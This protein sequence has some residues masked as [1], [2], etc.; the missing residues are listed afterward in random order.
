MAIVRKKAQMWSK[1]K[2]ISCY[3][4][5]IDH[6]LKKNT[7]Q[8][9]KSDDTQST[10]WLVSQFISK[11]EIEYDYDRMCKWYFESIWKWNEFPGNV[12]KMT[13]FDLEQRVQNV[14]RAWI[15]YLY[16]PIAL[17]KPQKK[18]NIHIWMNTHG[19]KIMT[20]I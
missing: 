4:K 5:S 15:L 17:C 12:D 13:S 9:T 10:D 2:D 6:I 8:R 16:K 3:K 14:Q 18:Y 11:L 7:T 20:I 19:M 1:L